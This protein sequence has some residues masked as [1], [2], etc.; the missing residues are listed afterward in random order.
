[1]PLPIH[2]RGGPHKKMAPGLSPDAAQV[3]RIEMFRALAGRCTQ[4]NFDSFGKSESHM[5]S[6]GL[7]VLKRQVQARAGGPVTSFRFIWRAAQSIPCT[8]KAGHTIR[9]P[10]HCCGTKKLS[11]SQFPPP[12][13]CTAS[14][15]ARHRKPACPKR[16]KRHTATPCGP[17]S[18][19]A[20]RGGVFPEM[21][22]HHQRTIK[23]RGAFTA[24]RPFSY[25]LVFPARR[26]QEPPA[27]APPS[28]V[29]PGGSPTTTF[30]STVSTPTFRVVPSATL[31]SI[32]V[33]EA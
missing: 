23:G 33:P 15:Q 12:A 16:S 2:G 6:D 1:M 20:A 31:L 4:Q 28:S 11:H 29:G 22:A 21:A 27:P 25:M 30:S 32:T 26:F 18:H 13:G 24:P 9:Q 5:Q 8:G 10:E 14:M 19:A 3:Q 7:P 17:A